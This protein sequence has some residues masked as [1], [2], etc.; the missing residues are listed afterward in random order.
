MALWLSDVEVSR[1]SEQNM[2]TLREFIDLVWNQGDIEAIDQFVAREYQIHHDPG[3]PWD[4]QTLSVEG[5]KERVRVSRSPIPD[6]R[7][8]IQTMLANDSEVQITWLWE[9]T[10]L[11]EIAG[12][13]PTAKTLRMSGA[14]VYYFSEGR[15]T[16][17]WQVADRMSIYQQLMENSGPSEDA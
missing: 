5:F 6:Q 15:I 16:G 12:F 3:D 8:D 7:F 4:G 17:H 13:A 11:G 10:H 1:M 14:T 2:R 9:G